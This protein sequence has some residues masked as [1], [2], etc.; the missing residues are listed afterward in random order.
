VWASI[1]YWNTL[2][3]SGL[4]LT[5][6]SAY[7]KRQAWSLTI[8]I[9]ILHFEEGEVSYYTLHSFCFRAWLFLLYALVARVAEFTNEHA[10]RCSIAIIILKY[11]L[12]I[13][14]RRWIVTRVVSSARLPS[15]RHLSGY[16][17][18]VKLFYK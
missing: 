18:S 6:I 15:G 8:Q 16:I 13:N 14:K 4:L 7:L 1:S 3:W 2:P 9:R 11:K 5:A 17:G 10:R 12:L